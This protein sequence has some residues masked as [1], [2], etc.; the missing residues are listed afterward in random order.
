MTP[1]R[2]DPASPEG[3]ATAERLSQALAEIKYAMWERGALPQKPKP[4]ASRELVTA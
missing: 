3:I 1:T 2:L 4:T